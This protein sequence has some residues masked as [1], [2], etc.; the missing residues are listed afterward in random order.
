MDDVH[1]INNQ[2]CCIL[3]GPPCRDSMH[4]YDHLVAYMGMLSKIWQTV[5][6]FACHF[7]TL[8]QA[9]DS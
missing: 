4:I 2:S 5:F 7:C 6:E 1:Q 9:T 8:I 3:S